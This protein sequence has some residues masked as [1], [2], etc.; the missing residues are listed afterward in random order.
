MQI[1]G[2]QKC[3]PTQ[4]SMSGHLK[5]LTLEEAYVLFWE[6][7]FGW[8]LLLDWFRTSFAESEKSG[9]VSKLAKFS[10]MDFGYKL[11]TR[12]ALA[13]AMNENCMLDEHGYGPSRNTFAQDARR[14][15]KLFPKKARPYESTQVI[16]RD[17][18]RQLAYRMIP[19]Q[20]WLIV[21]GVDAESSFTNLDVDWTIFQTP[22]DPKIRETV[23]KVLV[24][25]KYL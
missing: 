17:G 5:T 10:G 25:K 6:V 3:I 19:G 11:L 24:E 18:Y 12:G 23:L 21:V 4:C 20:K 14:F 8:L 15:A 9:Y 16:D 2:E 1:P 7:S 22:P 13:L